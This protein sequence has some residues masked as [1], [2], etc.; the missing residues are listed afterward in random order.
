MILKIIYRYES[1]GLQE[2]LD[3]L[4]SQNIPHRLYLV[5]RSALPSGLINYF[6]NETNGH[7]IRYL[8]KYKIIEDF[9]VK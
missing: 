5:S 6:V 7:I 3:I 4:K 1:K 9:H 2:V 8:F